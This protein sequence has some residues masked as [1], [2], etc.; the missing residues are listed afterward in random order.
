VA[1]AAADLIVSLS[2]LIVSVLPAERKP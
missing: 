1:S 2:A